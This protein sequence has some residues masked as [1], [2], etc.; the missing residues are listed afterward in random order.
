[1]AFQETAM[2]TL[3]LLACVKEKAAQPMPA[4]DLYRS[5]WFRKARAFVEAKHAPWLILSALHGVVDPEDVIAPYE[6]TLMTMRAAERRAWGERVVTQLLER[7]YE[8]GGRVV[9]LAGAMYREPISR[10][11]GDRASVP[12]RGL[13]IGEQLAWLT[14]ATACSDHPRLVF[15]GERTAEADATWPRASSRSRLTAFGQA[16]NA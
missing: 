10:W 15:P 3:H 5:V 1:M 7:S 11:L 9:I 8:D 6:Q 2:T 13:A 12:M 16:T 4:A 14:N